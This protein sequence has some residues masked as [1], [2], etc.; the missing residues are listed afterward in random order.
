[1]IMFWNRREVYF[2]NSLQEFIQVRE[3]L[4]A[5]NIPHRYRF[6]NN[7]RIHPFNSRRASSITSGENREYSITYY[8]Y[9]HKNDYEKA[10]AILQKQ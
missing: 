1:M 2:G 7:H 3:K 4:G 10:V 8:I 5:N 6:V 9:V